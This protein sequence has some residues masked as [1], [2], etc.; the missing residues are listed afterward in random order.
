[1]IVDHRN[2]G[3]I[4]DNI[5]IGY[6]MQFKLLEVWFDNNL[7][8]TIHHIKLRSSINSYKYFLYK[9]KPLCHPNML[10]MIYIAHIY[11]TDYITVY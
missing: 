4:I 10:Q 11:I 5:T 6:V 7:T 3:L 9:M 1:M 8:L 2:V